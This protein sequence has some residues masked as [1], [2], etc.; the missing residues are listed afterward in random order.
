MTYM[1]DI[2]A[3]LALKPNLTKDFFSRLR[4]FENSS[5]VTCIALLNS[6]EITVDH[7]ISFCLTYGEWPGHLE[8][9]LF[10]RPF[11]NKGTLR[12]VGDDGERW[13]YFFD[14]KGSVFPIVYQ[15]VIDTC[16]PIMG[17]LNYG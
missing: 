1:S 5:C 10:L 7:E 11:V 4:D 16:T 6:L 13:G 9:A 14:G 15:E 12:F 8:L 3:D 17:Q 2:R